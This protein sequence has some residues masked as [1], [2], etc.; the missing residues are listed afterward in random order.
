[1]TVLLVSQDLLW[2]GKV[3]GAASH[4]GVD[5]RVPERKTDI[6]QMWT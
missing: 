3:R 5:V 6:T 2:I 1:M 4:L